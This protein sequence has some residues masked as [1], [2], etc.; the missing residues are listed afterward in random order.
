MRTPSEWYQLLQQRHVPVVDWYYRHYSSLLRD[1]KQHARELAG[2]QLKAEFERTAMSQL[3]VALLDHVAPPP[4]HLTRWI[5]LLEHLYSPMRF[6]NDTA[7]ELRLRNSLATLYT[8]NEDVEKAKQQF[9]EIAKISHEMAE[10]D[11]QHRLILMEA[12]IGLMD[13]Q[14]FDRKPDSYSE[15]VFNT[16]YERMRSNGFDNNTTFSHFLSRTHLAV[17][18]I[19]NYKMQYENAQKALDMAIS[20]AR[21]ERETNPLLL[22]RIYTERGQSNAAMGEYTNALHDLDMAERYHAQA[23]YVLSAATLAY[24]RARILRVQGYY[25]NNRRLNQQAIELFR[26]A[27]SV[28]NNYHL[29]RRQTIY[30][31]ALALALLS[32][33]GHA[34]EVILMAKRC[35]DDASHYASLETFI[36]RIEFILAYTYGIQEEWDRAI[37]HVEN[38]GKVQGK[39][40][41]ETSDLLERPH[42]AD[43]M[44]LEKLRLVLLSQGDVR[45]LFH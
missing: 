4:D 35:L 14:Q 28:A 10:N 23:R 38:G 2:Q 41:K 42:H 17:G 26:T 31:M 15:E 18:R 12:I 30:R 22:G 3:I 33:E 21:K 13:L 37:S 11:P 16:L 25:Q 6:S 20:T 27:L 36:P 19:L 40:N 1:L 45:N 7:N 39:L 34:D 24:A 43:P 9:D 8:L 44:Q 29:P 5:R 32:E